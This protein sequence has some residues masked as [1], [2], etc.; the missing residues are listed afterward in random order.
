M[1]YSADNAWNVNLNNGNVNNNTKSN[2]N[3]NYRDSLPFSSISG[4]NDAV[5]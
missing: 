5:L 1:Q 4:I 3:S 2:A